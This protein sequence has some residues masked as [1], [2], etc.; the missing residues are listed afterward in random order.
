MFLT[1]LI[2]QLP[3]PDLLKPGINEE[4]E[5][6]YGAALTGNVPTMSE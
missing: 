3:L 2:L 6:V 1:H 5:D 4:N